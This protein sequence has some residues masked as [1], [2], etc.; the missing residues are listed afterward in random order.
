[1]W[2]RALVARLLAVDER[3][4]PTDRPLGELGID[5]LTAAEFSLEIEDSTGINAPLERFLG[6]DTLGDVARA[7]AGHIPMARTD[8]AEVTSA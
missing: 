3:D 7:L 2:L 4:V 6:D 8:L 5:S 1:L